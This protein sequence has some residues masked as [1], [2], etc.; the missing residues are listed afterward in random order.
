LGK[1]NSLDPLH[2]E[3]VNSKEEDVGREKKEG[4]KKEKSFWKFM[5]AT[6]VPL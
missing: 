6:L 3:E 2:E 5:I 1:R 4:K